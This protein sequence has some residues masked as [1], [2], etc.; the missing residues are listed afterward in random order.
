MSGAAALLV[1]FIA[2][3]VFAS[4]WSAGDLRS[5]GIAAVVCAVA[6]IV[7]HYAAMHAR[8]RVRR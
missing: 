8:K 3:I 1:A 2:F 4:S 5:A 6:I 7:W